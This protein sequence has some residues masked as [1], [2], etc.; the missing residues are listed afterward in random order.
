LLDDIFRLQLRV[1][2]F[3][4]GSKI[5]STFKVQRSKS[6]PLLEH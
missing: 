2:H 6:P 5:G 3:P 1:R 4:S